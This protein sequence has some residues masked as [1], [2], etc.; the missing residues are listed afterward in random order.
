MTPWSSQHAATAA[1]RRASPPGSPG[2]IPPR[3]NP[4][5]PF[6]PPFASPPG[7]ALS[8]LRLHSP[9]V[10]HSHA[11]T[12]RA[13]LATIGLLAA[14]ISAAG[15]VVAPFLANFCADCHDAGTRKGDFSL[16]GLNSANVAAAA[17]TWE[18]VVRKL[19]HRQMPPRGEV[20]PSTDEYDQVVATLTAALD[21]AAAARP[22]PGRTETLRRLNRTEYQNAIRDLLGVTIDASTL[23]PNDE[24]SHGFDNLAVGNL[25]PTLLDRYVTAAQKIARL[26]VGTPGRAPGSDTFRVRPDVTQEEHVDGL[27]LGTRGGILIP[28]PFP[29]TGEYEVQVRLQRDRNE[30]VEGLRRPHEIEVLLDRT[31]LATATVKPPGADKNA[32]AVDQHLRFRIT[33]PA[34]THALGVTFPKDPSALLETERAPFA[35]HFNMHRHPRTVPAVYQVTIT[36]PLV[37][38]G[39]GDTPSR[40]ILFGDAPAGPESARPPGSER[41]ADQTQEEERARA[42]LSRLARRAYR[43]PVNAD[44]LRRLLQFFRDGRAEG[45]F[46]A[47]I[48]A[49]L[50]ALLISPQFL[51][52]IE[53]DPPD[54]V[55]GAAHRISDL[56]LASRLS[57]FL[58]SSLP[59]EALLDAALRGELR[60]PA[61]LEAQVRRLLA[62]DRARN[63]VDNFAA[64]WLHLR[65]L[66]AFTPDARRFIDFDDNLRQALRRETELFVADVFRADRPVTELLSADYTFLNERLA[67]HYRVPH[68]FGSQF[69]RVSFAGDPQRQRGGLLRHGSLLAVTSYATRTSP[70]LRGNWIL[71]NLVGEP[72]PP[73]PPNTPNLEDTVIAASLPI[74]QRLAQHRENPRCASCH[75]LMDPVG[76]A[77]ENYD[78]VGRWRTEEDHRAIDAR[79][80]L[81]DGT[82]FDGV[83]GLEQ[84]IL[85]RPEL[86][87]STFTGK[88]LT[89]AL[90][91]GIEP[92]DAPALREIVR[93]ARA[94]DYRFSEI[95]L[96]IVRS[97]PFQMREAP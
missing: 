65:G 2:V 23:L 78:A 82:V 63:L 74:R 5:P 85:A 56:E 45:G 36:G 84:A 58:W 16:E 53:T 48:E 40:R 42:L 20:R 9:P 22:R 12:L 34:G 44:D 86:F 15:D 67:R 93:R 81:P 46:E 80:G 11:F 94:H 54:A 51:F 66:E 27:P 95:V 62:D 19:E 91:R 33:A 30:Q 72:A 1:G 68:V 89:F 77:L 92:G 50:T 4:A 38:H 60:Q 61:G 70:V 75:D 8:S 69:R 55:R 17:A 6:T 26:A 3:E 13:C 41:F 7:P 18:R 97:V 73:P 79:G 96:G 21:R 28:Y 10:P 59:D 25:S 35:S 43:R 24:P 32:E 87:V 14:P 88:L 31:R 76:F 52:R 29:Q 49:S 83:A 39:L 37:T 71:A 47:G 90:G 64:Q 57:F